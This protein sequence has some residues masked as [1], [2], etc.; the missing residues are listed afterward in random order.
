MASRA[1]TLLDALALPEDTHDERLQKRLQLAMALA[2]VPVVALWGA[3]FYFSGHASAARWDLFYCAATLGLVAFAVVTRSYGPFR[4]LHPLLVLLAPFALHWELGGFRGSGGAILWCTIAPVATMMFAG[5]RRSLPTFLGMIVLA[6]VGFLRDGPLAPAVLGLS[7]NEASFHFA[8]NT[9]GVVGFLYLST[10]HFVS[11]IDFEKA[12]SER[13]L[14][15]VLPAAI[16]ERLKRDDG[17]IADRHPSVTVL[18]ADIAGFTPLAAR[19]PARD[20]VL[21]LN[22]IFSAFD[23]IADAHGLEKIKTIG[24]AYMLVGG[25]PDPMPDHAVRVAEAALAMRDFIEELAQGRGLDLS[26]RIGIHSGEVVAGVIGRRKF[27]YDLWGDT[28]NTASRMESHGAP[29]RVHA[30]DAT[31]ALLGDAVRCV[32]RGTIVVKGKGEMRT[33]WIERPDRVLTSIPASRPVAETSS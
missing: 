23:Q 14:R 20:V 25:L 3:M 27:A 13:L 6:A 10:R 32:E 9:I 11:R 16:A 5:P 28:V 1:R 29:G 15:N 18:F 22:E 31:R 19:L 8:F 4:H 24:D 21:V 12:R 2:S 26:M 17:T 33:H 30:S 7:P